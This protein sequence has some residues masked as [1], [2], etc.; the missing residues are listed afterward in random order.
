LSLTRKQKT[1]IQEL[2]TSDNW[3]SQELRDK[4]SRSGAR[5]GDL[6]TRSLVTTDIPFMDVNSFYTRVFGGVY[7]IRDYLNPGEQSLLVFDERPDYDGVY[8]S[9]K[10]TV[11]TLK[12]LVS[13]GFFRLEVSRL[14][15]DEF[16]DNL[17]DTILCLQLYRDPANKDMNVRDMTIAQK[18]AKLPGLIESMPHYHE[19]QRL[20]KKVKRKELIGEKEQ[21]KAAEAMSDDA[22]NMLYVPSV[23]SE[24]DPNFHKLMM[25]LLVS[26]VTVPPEILYVYNREL[27]IKR[28]RNWSKQKKRWARAQIRKKLK[29]NKS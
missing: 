23:D 2:K 5:H 6:R 10:N 18:R 13:R 20:A 25:H 29:I 22:K 8:L 9:I 11:S 12:E 4:L 15:D 21:I 3:I 27:F 7:V 16:T 28:Y 14:E 1:L 17:L 19:I 24:K 26:L